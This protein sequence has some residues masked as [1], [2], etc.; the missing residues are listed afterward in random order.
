M[1]TN[2]PIGSNCHVAESLR[3]AG[4]RT[5]SYPFDWVAMNTSM[6]TKYPLK[7]MSL[8]TEEVE[9]FCRDF[10]SNDKIHLEYGIAFPHDDKN[11]ICEKYTRRIK[12][13]FEHIKS[14][15][16]VN[17]FFATRWENLDNEV[18][19]IFEAFKAINPNVHLYT[20]NAFKNHAPSAYKE[21]ITCNYIAYTEYHIPWGLDNSRNWKYDQT[22]YKDFLIKT[23]EELKTEK[24]TS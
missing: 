17:L 4:I 15:K 9:E 5:F 2:I 24:F 6:Y 22:V 13:M 3:V 10:F 19:Q 21:F 20:V 16:N 7:I 14:A 8:K 1:I 11:N 23:Y 12:R 18:I